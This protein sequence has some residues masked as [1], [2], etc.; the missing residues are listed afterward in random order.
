MNFWF[1]DLTLFPYDA[2]LIEK[3]LL[4]EEELKQINDYH[5]H[6]YAEFS[7]RLEAD[8]KLGSS[9]CVRKFSKKESQAETLFFILFHSRGLVNL[10]FLQA[11]CCE[12]V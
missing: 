10:Y 9:H 1:R 11:A 3:S 6:V 5:K 4:N 8:K 2:R 12:G 7:E